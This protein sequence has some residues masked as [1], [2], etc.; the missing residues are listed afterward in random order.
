MP[1]L[2]PPRF[3]KEI[4]ISANVLRHLK[5]RPQALPKQKKATG[6]AGRII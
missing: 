6:F 2:S 5:I 3:E 4:V 1:S